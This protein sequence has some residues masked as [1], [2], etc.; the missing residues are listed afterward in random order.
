MAR[1]NVNATRMELSNLKKRLEIAEHGY[2]LLKDKQDELMRQFIVL[3]KENRK[4]RIDVEK[5]LQQSFR[6]FFVASSMMSPQMLESAV[7]FPKENISLHIEEKNIMSVYV[8]IINFKRELQDDPGSIFP[9]GYV[10]TSS[11]LDDAIERLYKMIPSLLK[12]AEI[13]KTCQLMADEIE[14]T[15]RRVNALEHRTIPDLEETIY[16]IEMKLDESERS[17]IT[18]LIKVKDLIDKEN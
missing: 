14:K 11:E 9:Y 6:D 17:T 8:P 4:L 18:R 16:F 3:V 1:L 7:S 15:R 5:Q 2:K 10:Q 12:L 13:E